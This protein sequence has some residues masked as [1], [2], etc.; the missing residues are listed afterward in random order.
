[1]EFVKDADTKERFP[2]HMAFGTRVGKAC[3]KNG[4]ILRSDAN[5]VTLAPP[6]ISTEAQIEEMVS[7]LAKSLEQVLME[8]KILVPGHV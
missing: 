2:P 7:I 3:L 5:T 6:L 1:V 8:I 4:L